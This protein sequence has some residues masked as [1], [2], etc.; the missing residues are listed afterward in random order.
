MRSVD[1]SFKLPAAT[2]F[3]AAIGLIIFFCCSTVYAADVTLAWDASSSSVDGYHLYMH[4]AGQAYNYNSP[5]WSGTG[6]T[7]TITNL[8]ANTYYFVARAYKSNN[9]SANSNEVKYSA[10][11][12]QS[13]QA[14]A[15]TDQAVS[16][17]TLV[18]LNGSG[19]TDPDGSIASYQWT[20]TSGPSVSLSNA[21]AAQTSF[22]APSVT[23]NTTLGFQLTVTD[24]GGLS[25]T[26]SCQVTIVPVAL[27]NSGAGSTGD[28]GGGGNGGTDPSNPSAQ[29]SSIF[30]A[31]HEAIIDNGDPGTSSTGSWKD[32]SGSNYYGSISLCSQV[33]GSTYSFETAIN[34][35]NQVS[36]WWTYHPS[37]NTQVPVQ[38]YDGNQLLDVVYVNQLQ[39][40]GQWNVLGTYNFTGTARVVVMVDSNDYSSCADAVKF[41]SDEVVIDNGDPGTS[42]TGSWKNSSGPNYYGSVSLC[43]QISGSTYSFETTINGTSQISMWWT[44]HPSRSTEVPVQIYDGN[45]L[46]DVVYINQ[47]QNGGQWNVLGTYNFTGL[48]RVVVMAD[49]NDYSSCAD[50][51]KFDCNEVVIDNGDLGTS[52]TGSWGNSSGPNYYGSISL[53]SQTSGSTYSF[54]TAINGTSQVSMWWTYHPS[55]N[56]QVPVRIYDGDQLLDV[57][58]VNQ[59]QNGGQWNVLGTYKF[60]GTAKVVIVS[61]SNEYS[62]CADAVKFAAE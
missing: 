52:S 31:I 9:E 21:A 27:G 28:S 4:A 13:P 10:V 22:T 32:S 30:H 55:R 46:L 58:Y 16:A 39:N 8:A 12:N 34:G 7:C 49:S 35:T 45:Q 1:F 29:K 61:D 24:S 17:G 41:D 25:N 60:T 48:A 62:A 19:S 18:T 33:S 50:A 53:Y 15:G 37:R 36:M 51:V 44:Y 43:S 56:T 57:V 40:G 38:I 26:D 54:E 14:N 23:A 6:T 20:Q 42:S 47:L 5:V 3:C 59:L 11:V 2:L